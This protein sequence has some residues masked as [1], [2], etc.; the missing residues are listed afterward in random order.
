MQPARMALAA[1]LWA[2]GVPAEFGYKANPNLGDSLRAAD[3]AGVPFVC[4][5][6]P[7]EVEK[8]VVR[9]RDMVA[10]T[11]EEVG[12]DEAPGRIAAELAAA[13]PRGLVAGRGVGGGGSG[14][15]GEGGGKK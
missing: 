7:A 13:G 5:L 3:A 6:G 15:G 2:A 10:G 12:L 4:V 1:S 11:E 8:G 14:G 9:V